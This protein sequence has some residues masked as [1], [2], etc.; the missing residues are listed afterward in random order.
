MKNAIVSGN[1]TIIDGRSIIGKDNF[2]TY[3]CSSKYL[4]IYKSNGALSTDIK[5]FRSSDIKAK[6]ICL[7]KEENEEF[8][9]IPLVHTLR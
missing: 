8:V 1:D 3:P 7:P 6:M 5:K 4:N 2:F 9:Y